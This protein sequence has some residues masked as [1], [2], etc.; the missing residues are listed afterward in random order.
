MRHH[1]KGLVA[2]AIFK[3]FKALILLVLTIGLLKMVHADVAEAAEK[4]IRALRVDPDNRYLGWLLAK[5]YLVDDKKLETLSALSFAYSAL[6]LVEGT[7]LYFEKHWAE[8]LTIIATASFIPLE[9]YELIKEPNIIKGILLLL[10]VGIV[11]FL[12]V[13]VRRQRHE[14]RARS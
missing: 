14:K 9:V 10:N 4:A 1:N 11:V 13:I 3:W 12:V 6:F 2:I 5:L 8:Y 7:G